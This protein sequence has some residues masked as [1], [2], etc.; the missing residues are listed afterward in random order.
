M[1]SNAFRVTLPDDTPIGL[2]FEPTLALANHSCSPNAVVVF[3]GRAIS[4]RALTE[5][6]QGEEIFISYIDS[7]QTRDKRRQELEYGYFFTCK[8]ERCTNDEISYQTFLRLQPQIFK[9]RSRLIYQLIDPT[10]LVEQASKL[11]AQ[12]LRQCNN[13]VLGKSLEVEIKAV[14]V[15]LDNIARNRGELEPQQQLKHLKEAYTGSLEFK[16]MHTK[17]ICSLPAL[18]PYP[19]IL[20]NIYLAYLDTQSWIPALICLLSLA[21]HTD[22]FTYPVP[23]HPVRVVRLYTIARLFKHISTLTPAEFLGAVGSE[24]RDILRTFTDIGNRV[25]Y[26]DI[27]QVLMA[28]VSEE[29][30]RSYGEGSWFAREVEVEVAELTEARKGNGGDST[31]A[32]GRW[33]VDRKDEEG[34]RVVA[35]VS[36]VLW[37]LADCVGPLIGDAH[38]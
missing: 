2:C 34:A 28:I 18:A 35:V 29:V 1:T 15:T 23:H 4:L 31:A 6:K 8:C 14:Q 27:L 21:L 33:I 9:D 19:L 13:S 17:T 24:N 5:I 38:V 11:S 20:Q 25:E 30:G 37:K 3:D 32:L 16:D 22:P 26:E 36:Q 7:T 12:Y 10:V